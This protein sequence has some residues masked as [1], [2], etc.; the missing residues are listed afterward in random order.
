MREQSGGLRKIVTGDIFHA[1]SG[2]Y[3][4]R[5]SISPLL[6]DI[7]EIEKITHVIQSSGDVLG[8]KGNVKNGGSPARQ[9]RFVYDVSMLVIPDLAAL[10]L[11]VIR[12]HD[13]AS[14]PGHV[15]TKTNEG[16]EPEP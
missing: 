8:F 15:E 2:A 6:C 4:I 9:Q 12:G 3:I 1:G 7:T 5:L 16:I 13:P 10:R 14:G 11:V